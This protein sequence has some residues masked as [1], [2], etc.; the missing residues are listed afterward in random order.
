[1]VIVT[2][3]KVN[4]KGRGNRHQSD[5]RW[6]AAR[7]PIAPDLFKIRERPILLDPPLRSAF[8]ACGYQLADDASYLFA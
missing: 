5:M 1:M 4:A 6:R 2:T 3:A 7:F 8:D